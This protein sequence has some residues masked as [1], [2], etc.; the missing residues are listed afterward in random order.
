MK[1]FGNA[2]PPP[3]FASEIRLHINKS[4]ASET[5][6]T[7]L[8]KFIAKQAAKYNLSHADLQT[9]LRRLGCPVSF[10]ELVS[11]EY[12]ASRDHLRQDLLDGFGAASIHSRVV[13]SEFRD[14]NDVI[15]TLSDPAE[16]PIVLDLNEEGESIAKALEEALA[17][18]SEYEWGNAQSVHFE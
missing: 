15:L 5:E 1:L 12:E 9:D 8:V 6:Q 4:Q 10:I 14:N 3:W 7:A 11:K 13:Q 18:F 16:R 2:A 17:S